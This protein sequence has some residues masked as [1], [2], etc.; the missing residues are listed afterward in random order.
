MANIIKT[1]YGRLLDWSGLANVPAALKALAGL[2]GSTGQIIEISGTD[3]DGTVS[4]LTAVDKPAGNG[5]V[6]PTKVSA[7]ENDAGYQTAEQVNALLAE[8]P[9]FQI[10]VVQELPSVGEK[11]TIYLVPFADDSGSYLEYLYVNGAWEVVGSGKGSGENVA[12]DTT[13]AVEGKAADAKAVG[14]ALAGKV[15]GIGITTIMAITQAKYDELVMLEQVDETTLYIIKP[16]SEDAPDLT[17]IPVLRSDG[18]AYINLGNAPV[19][20][21]WYEVCFRGVGDM[22]NGQ[23]VFGNTGTAIGSVGDG[24]NGATWMSGSY[25]GSAYDT[26]GQVDLSKKHIFQVTTT[27]LILDG[28][29]KAQITAGFHPIGRSMCLFARNQYSFN[30][31][32]QSA[33]ADFFGFSPCSIDLFYLRIWSSENTLLH[34]YVPAQDSEGVA[35][36]Y[37]TVDKAYLYNAAEAGAFE[38]REELEE[39]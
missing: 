13:L 17:M 22:P 26:Y 5:A 24:T 25:L 9:T 35:C 15:A 37:D 8:F 32:N 29:E 6:I 10:E 36:I 28:E 30:N 1:I 4:A 14:D 23:T 20:G 21:E 16:E 3:G 38:Y 11:K 34:N 31:N 19:A 18:T 7:F 2:K 33:G 12:L 27:A 39:S